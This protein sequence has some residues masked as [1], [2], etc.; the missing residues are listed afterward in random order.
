MSA[1]R[2]C[3]GFV[4]ENGK[5]RPCKKTGNA[6]MPNN[7]CASHQYIAVMKL[8]EQ[9][10][11]AELEVMRLEKVSDVNV[12][13]RKLS[14]LYQQIT[15]LKEELQTAEKICSGDKDCSSHVRDLL[16]TLKDISQPMN[17]GYDI[18]RKDLPDHPITR[19]QNIE[20]KMNNLALGGSPEDAQAFQLSQEY[21][22]ARRRQNYNAADIQ[23]YQ[24]ELQEK[25]AQ[26]ENQERKFQQSLQSLTQEL[27]INEG[28]KMQADQVV[29]SLQKRMDRC[30]AESR[31]VSGV[32]S[33]TINKLKE[34]V[35][36]YKDLYNNMVGREMRVGKTVDTLAEN[37]KKLQKALEELKQNYEMKMSKLRDDFA[38]QVRV[39][40]T[41][42]SVR[43]EQLQEEVQKLKADLEL[44]LTDLKLATEAGK[45][46]INRAV[47]VDR[48]YGQIAEELIRVN[49]MLRSKNQEVSELQALHDKRTSEF[50]QAELRVAQ[51]IDEAS[52]RDRSEIQRLSG[53]LAKS[54]R[55]LSATH[56]EIV[57]LNTTAYELRRQ[58]Q[59]E[60]QKINNQLRDTQNQ[61]LQV[62]QQRE[63]EKRNLQQQYQLMKTQTESSKLEQDFKFN[64]MKEAL[65]ENYKNKVKDIQDRAEANQLQLDQERRNMQIAQKQIAETVKVMAKQKEDLEKYRQAYDKK[66]ADFLA[67]KES[68][69]TAL[70]QAKEQANQFAQIEN[71]YK[72]RTDILRQT[73][74]VQRQ[75][76]EARINQLT[77]KL[78]QAITNRNQIINSLEKCNA[79]RD[80]V[81]A[82]VNLLTDENARLK[83][84]YLQMKSKA[85]ITRSQY[86]AHMEK[87]RADSAQMQTDIRICAQK[88]QDATL[89]HDHV[90]RM[91]GEAQQL[92]LQLEE[93]I[94]VAKGSEQALRRLLQDRELEKQ[95]VFRLQ[96]ALKDCSVQKSQTEVGLE[97]T[98]TE[99]RD[100]KRMHNKLSGEI[101]GMAN[102]YQRAL[103][104]REA[105][106][107]RQA[108]E[109]EVREQTLQNRLA[110]TQARNN[111]RE[112]QINKLQRQKQMISD[113]LAN[114]EYERARQIQLLVDAQRVGSSAE[115]VTGKSNL[116][117]T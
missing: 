40:G 39:G 109:Q 33:E 69:N 62:K 105:G 49:E 9:L 41:V 68:L 65:N 15:M 99:L 101:K 57:A 53:E 72:K 11:L 83:D 47:S 10:E 2:T 37:E 4:Q 6:V 50:A 85:D 112:S 56:Q 79:S 108:L 18:S 64:Q 81:L 34:E 5:V 66:L 13:K 45:E 35:Q 86:E 104:E 96:A 98:N 80:S 23:M 88:L 30:Q 106:M 28:R 102:D 52:A 110:E 114:T 89:V 60:I 75:R 91:K 12:D 116:V 84:M 63:A 31:Q 32:Y 43:E 71:D 117:Q 87:L 8:K 16:V 24:A 21:E 26:A 55:K 111:E 78:K 29:D 67:Q 54:E 92:R 93:Q 115:P 61:L 58:H 113:S 46:A 77:E 97:N 3:Q 27:K 95:Q 51:K 14:V 44:A 7:Y 70:A 48:P 74:A 38:S 25:S 76:Y 73:V 36:Q 107:A 17:G 1:S 103:E 20:K 19:L 90:K 100:I 94:R 42:L 82:K 59:N 22:L